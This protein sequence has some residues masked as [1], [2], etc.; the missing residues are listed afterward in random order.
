MPQSRKSKDLNTKN[1]T[2]NGVVDDPPVVNAV[3]AA[4]PAVPNGVEVGYFFCKV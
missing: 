2:K 4:A 3:A 1:V